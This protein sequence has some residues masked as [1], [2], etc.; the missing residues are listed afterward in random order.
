MATPAPRRRKS[1]VASVSTTVKSSIVVSRD[2][3]TRWQAAASIR[4]MTAN[5]FAVEA[6]TEALR[7]IVVIDRNRVEKS[8]RQGPGFGISSDEEDAA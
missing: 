6:L 2:T 7:G 4:G 3:H 8:Y 1:A 5:A